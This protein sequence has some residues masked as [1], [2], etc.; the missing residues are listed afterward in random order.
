MR[1]ASFGP[2]PGRAGDRDLV[3]QG[4]GGG[5]LVGRQDRENGERDFR[6]DALHVLQQAEPVALGIGQKA[7]QAD[8]VLA[9]LRLDGENRSLAGAR[10]FLQGAGGA[11]DDI[12]DAMHV[13]DHMILV[14]GIH[15]ALEFADHLVRPIRFRV[16]S[17]EISV[18]ANKG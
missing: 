17:S 5:Q 9:H 1:A 13:E 2:T 7:E 14:Q 11:G 4:D 8:R 18:A 6:A 12:A 16:S 15:H 3:L 10:Q